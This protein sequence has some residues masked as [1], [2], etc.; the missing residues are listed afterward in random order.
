MN[1][2]KSIVMAIKIGN[3]K[4]SFVLRFRLNSGKESRNFKPRIEDKTTE[5]FSS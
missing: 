1:S 5:R 4:C 3:R 2:T